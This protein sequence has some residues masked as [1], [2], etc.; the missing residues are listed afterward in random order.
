MADIQ[1]NAAA[2]LILATEDGQLLVGERGAAVSFMQGFV[3]VPGGKVDPQD[4]QTAAALWPDDPQGA[5][6]AAAIREIR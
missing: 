2:A 3:S 5:R 6:K 1:P 4:H